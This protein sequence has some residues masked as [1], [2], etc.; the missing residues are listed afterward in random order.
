MQ[1]ID[2]PVTE[3]KTPQSVWTSRGNFQ[4]YQAEPCLCLCVLWEC[5]KRYI[6]DADLVMTSG[7]DLHAS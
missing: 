1:R 2:F 5:L 4:G 6:A 7:R 3:T